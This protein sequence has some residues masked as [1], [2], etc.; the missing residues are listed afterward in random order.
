MSR[1]SLLP[2]E[3]VIDTY[4]RAKAKAQLRPLALHFSDVEEH[5]LEDYNMDVSDEE[6]DW[7]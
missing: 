7:M 6:D 3:S 2:E 1:Y 5:L 4:L